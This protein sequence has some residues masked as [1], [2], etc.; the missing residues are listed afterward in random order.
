MSQRL[1]RKIDDVL[2]RLNHEQR[3]VIRFFLRLWKI[4]LEMWVP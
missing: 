4:W 2:Y 3:P 1:S